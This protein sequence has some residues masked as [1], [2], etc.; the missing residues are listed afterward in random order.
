MKGLD[1]KDESMTD[2]KVQAILLKHML[3]LEEQKRDYKT[4]KNVI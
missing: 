1:P 4:K 3:D 2:D